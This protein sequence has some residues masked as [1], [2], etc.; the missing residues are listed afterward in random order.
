V[1]INTADGD[2]PFTR[3]AQYGLSLELPPAAAAPDGTVMRNM[4]MMG[5]RVV[6]QH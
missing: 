4:L 6:S 3:S 2:N 1:P 5:S